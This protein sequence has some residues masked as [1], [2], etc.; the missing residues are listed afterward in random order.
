MGGSIIVGLGYGDEG[1]GTITDYLARK[2]GNYLIIRYNGGSQAAHNVVTPEGVHHTFAQFG[3]AT[4]I[5]NVLSYLSSFMLVDPLALYNEAV[6]LKQKGI[7]NPFSRL[8]V[9]GDCSLITPFHIIIN[10]MREI[11]RRENRHGSCGMGVGEAMQDKI[12]L[13]AKVILARDLLNETVLKIKLRYLFLLKLDLAEQFLDQNPENQEVRELFAKF[14]SWE[15]IDPLIN[16]YRRILAAGL[17]IIS[18]EKVRKIV[19]KGVNLIF[20]GAQGT[21]LDTDYGFFPYIT[22]TNTTVANARKLIEPLGLEQDLPTLGILRA[23]QT[24]HGQGPLVTEDQELTEKVVD[25]HN[26]FNPWQGGFRIG[27]FD[28][29]AA[30][31]ALAANGK[32]DALVL[33]N[34]DG[35]NFSP[36]IRICTA[37]EYL[38][39]KTDRLDDY[40]Q[41]HLGTQKIKIT[42][43]KKNPQKQDDEYAQ[44]LFNCR[45]LEFENFHSRQDLVSY[46]QSKQGLGIPIRIISRGPTW[47]DKQEL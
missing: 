35:L 7:R 38:G 15:N 28:L 42:G 10:Q 37:Y 22:K 3:S 16:E 13:G 21:L 41:C 2:N 31:H 25:S 32:V 29:L 30:R 12:N 39:K 20:E 11:S 47:K 6:V 9:D 14:M 8:Y 44:M 46:L 5:P 26:R 27:W 36:Q 1:K 19:A 4:L 17:Q 43:L 34:I 18:L 45:P 23:Y 33:T 40:F 24:R